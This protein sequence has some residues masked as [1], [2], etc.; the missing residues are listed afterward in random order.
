MSTP[1]SDS[2]VASEIERLRAERDALQAQLD[3]MQ[4][5]R[6]W[7]HPARRAT[8]VV[9]VVLTCVSLTAAS[10][11]VWANRTLLTTDGWV[12]TIGPLGSDPAVTT[13]L[14]PRIT[15]AVFTAVP[16]EDLI[17]DTLPE[18][19]AF[20]AAPLSSA[21]EGFV[22]DQVGAFL[23]SNAFAEL[24]VNTNAVAHERVLTVLR[25]DSEAV[26][27]EGDTVTLNLL[28]M[29]N[30]VLMQLEGVASGL[31]G[32]DVDLPEITSE[33]YPSRLASASTPPWASSCPPTS[34]RS[35]STMPTSS[36]SRSRRSSCSTRPWCCS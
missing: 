18:E 16:A 4:R 36:S 8:A 28:P 27:I 32:Q 21:I 1:E 14:Q 7:R 6:R 34:A 13:A 3:T 22:D 35:P 30:R 25:G 23:A 33:R 15:E 19:R 24:W 10:V 26:Q 29:I 17:A 31:I 5:R 2:A 12:E 9:L 11:A 20:L